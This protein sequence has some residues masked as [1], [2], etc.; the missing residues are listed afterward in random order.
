M[1]CKFYIFFKIFLAN[2]TNYK[3][4]LHVLLLHNTWKFLVID[5][6]IGSMSLINNVGIKGVKCLKKLCGRYVKNIIR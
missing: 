6:N 4:F 3:V 1:I 5:P 2:Q